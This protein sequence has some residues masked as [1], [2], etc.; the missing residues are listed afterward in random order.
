MLDMTPDQA[1]LMI[2]VFMEEDISPYP[3][4]IPT[5]DLVSVVAICC[6]SVKIVISKIILL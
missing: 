5:S 3:F 6:D 4:S 2:H 1:Q